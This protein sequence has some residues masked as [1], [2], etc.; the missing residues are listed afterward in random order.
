MAPLSPHLAKPTLQIA[1]RSLL[2]RTLDNLASCGVRHAWVVTH[3]QAAQVEADAAAWRG[4]MRV[5]CTPQGASRGTGHAVASALQHLRGDALLV[6]GDGLCSPETFHELAQAE[7]FTLAASRVAEPQRYGALA[8][9]GHRVLDIAEKSPTPPSDLVNTGLYRVPAAA[10]QATRELSPSPRG[11]LE[12]TDV[13]RD[14]AKQGRVQWV[15]AQDWMDV[16]TPWDL[17]DAQTR[18]LADMEGG[19]PG[20]VEEGVHVRGRLWVGEGA[21]VKSGTY[22]EGNVHVGA[23]SRIGPNAYLRGPVGI[24]KGCHVGAGTEVKASLFMDGANAP[25]LNYVGDSV[26]GPDV[27]LGAGTKVANLKVTP[28]TVRAVGPN[29][30]MDTGRRKFGVALGPGVKT[31]I[32]ASLMPGTLVGADSLLGAGR[33]HGG[34]VPPSSRLL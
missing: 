19:G 1:G 31:G 23:G 18:I 4:S 11:E 15:P 8:V 10:L 25:H 17:L 6:M 26:L 21:V 12:F 14:W 33:V 24:G 3:H 5:A 22:I 34:W 7:G 20:V 28:G 2:H 29:G 16:G 9:D 32:N 30:P 27:N 13:V